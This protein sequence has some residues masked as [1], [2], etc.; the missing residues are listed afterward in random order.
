MHC[1]QARSYDDRRRELC[2]VLHFLAGASLPTRRATKSRCQFV[3]RPAHTLFIVSRA[4]LS[5]TRLGHSLYTDI[6]IP[7]KLETYQS[8]LVESQIY[9]TDKA[10]IA[11]VTMGKSKSQQ[12]RQWVVA[13]GQILAWFELRITTKQTVGC[14]YRSNFFAW[15]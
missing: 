13:T 9:V 5:Q 10:K 1:V 7:S 8:I 3:T 6:I 11:S 4:L 14:G 12:N 15:T 2:K